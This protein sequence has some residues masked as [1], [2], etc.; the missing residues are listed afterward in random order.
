MARSISENKAITGPLQEY[1][2]NVEL[3]KFLTITKNSS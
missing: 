3:V 1:K 2:D